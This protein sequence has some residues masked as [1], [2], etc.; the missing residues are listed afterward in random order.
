MLNET[1]FRCFV[2]CREP[3]AAEL[4]AKL[5][6]LSPCSTPLALNSQPLFAL[7]QGL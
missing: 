5:G 3:S 1:T 6:D 7:L 4:V 2:S